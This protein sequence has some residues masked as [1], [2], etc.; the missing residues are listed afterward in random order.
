[1]QYIVVEPYYVLCKKCY[2]SAF[3]LTNKDA[4]EERGVT[5][6]VVYKCPGKHFMSLSLSL[7]NYNLLWC[8]NRERGKFLLWQEPTCYTSTCQSQCIISLILHDWNYEY[9]I[10]LCFGLNMNI[11]C[12]PIKNGSWTI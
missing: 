3:R 4:V 7:Y 1:M 5:A 9:T 6:L 11:T 12:H 2:N 8:H 10:I